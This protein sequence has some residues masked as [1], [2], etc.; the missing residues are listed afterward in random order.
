[1][2]ITAQVTAVQP[3]R[4]P[5]I[6]PAPWVAPARN[7]F[8]FG[9]SGGGGGRTADTSG[10]PPLPPPDGLPMLPLP[11]AQPALRLLGLLT[12]AD[13]A[14]VAVLSIGA[15]LVMAR[16]GELV[17]SRFRVVSISDDS[18]ELDDAVGQRPI[19]LSLP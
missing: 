13:G 6:A 18:V 2:P 9:R 19:R 4:Q 5:V 15:D 7:L 3:L 11:I 16:T 14:K 12:F 1:M 17:G 10:L 8:R